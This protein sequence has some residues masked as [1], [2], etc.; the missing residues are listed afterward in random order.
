MARAKGFGCI[1]KSHT[2]RLDEVT[3]KDLVRQKIQIRETTAK[4]ADM[5]SMIDKV[6]QIKEKQAADLTKLEPSELEEIPYGEIREMPKPKQ[7]QLF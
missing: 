7:R 1:L 6:I 3:A 5:R 2:I 4:L